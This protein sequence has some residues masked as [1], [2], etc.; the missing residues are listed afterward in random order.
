MLVSLS[1][2]ERGK[3]Y[4]FDKEAV[5][6]GTDKSCD[7]RIVEGEN[8]DHGEQ[9]SMIIAEILRR[10]QGFQLA[11]RNT[12]KCKISINNNPL[13]RMPAGNEVELQDGDLI[14]FQRDPNREARFSLHFIE[15]KSVIPQAVDTGNGPHRFPEVDVVGHIHPLTATKFLKGLATSLWAEIPQSFKFFT[16]TLAVAAVLGAI[17]SL[18]FIFYKLDTQSALIADLNNQREEYENKI[19]DLQ[20]KNAD[21]KQRMEEETLRS[22]SAQR[23]IETYEN[24]VCLIQGVYTY[25]NVK[26]SEPLRY[27]D[28]SFNNRPIA[29]EKG[30]L[31]V[32]FEGTGAIYYES[33]S[34]TGFL[35][36]EGKI[37]TNR[38]VIH[39]WWDDEIGSLIEAQGGK[40]QTVE[41]YSYFPGIKTRF[42]LEV[43]KISTD[44]DIAYCNFEQGNAAITPVPLDAS[45]QA[46]AKGELII[47]IGYP[48]GVDGLVE[49]LDDKL[50]R[51]IERVASNPED[52]THEVARKGLIHPLTTQGHISGQTAGR[53]IHDAQTTDGASGSPI[54]NNDGKVIGINSAVLVNERGSIVG[55]SNLGIPIRYAL[56]ILKPGKQ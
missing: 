33:F 23:I 5:L 34:G 15:E 16:M 28:S 13:T 56:D 4:I 44:H 55:A 42:D 12:D 27:L 41:L 36:E 18:I 22:K 26:T 10:P 20:K 17:F 6:I 49:R 45:N 21:L 19:N 8:G 38:H 9:S 43:G 7:L 51:E 53:L 11:R 47:I 52:R 32:S 29:D 40:P 46:A 25:V 30:Q 54:F 14:G 24:S 48:T 37:L 31:N 1:G 35:V 39:P 3:T 2:S 50:K